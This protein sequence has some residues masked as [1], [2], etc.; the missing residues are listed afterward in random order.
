MFIILYFCLSLPKTFAI[1]LIILLMQFQNNL[2]SIPF[3]TN[4][5]EKYAYWLNPSSRGFSEP[6]HTQRHYNNNFFR[7]SSA[8]KICKSVLFCIYITKMLSSRSPKTT[9]EITSQL[10]NAKINDENKVRNIGAK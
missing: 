10:K 8:E 6:S 7:Y 2:Q 1:A 9:Q 4:G 5:I 3:M